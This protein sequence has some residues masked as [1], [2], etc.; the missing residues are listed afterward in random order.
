MN[1]PFVTNGYVSPIY[2]CDR[3][4]ELPANNWTNYIQKRSIS[5]YISMKIE[6]EIHSL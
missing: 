5:I 2:F 4:K 3:E 6:I 1:N